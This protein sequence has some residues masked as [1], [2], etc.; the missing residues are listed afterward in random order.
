MIL[1]FKKETF[2]LIGIKAVIFDFDGTL[3]E[4]EYVW[5]KAKIKIAQEEAV[6]L[7]DNDIEPF[8]GQKALSDKTSLRRAGWSRSL[9]V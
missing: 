6:N 8:V 5:S 2:Y 4:T 3:V 1:K 7:S 9:S